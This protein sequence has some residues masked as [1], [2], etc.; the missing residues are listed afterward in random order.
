MRVAG[1]T[2]IA[3]GLVPTVIVA[4]STVLVAVSITETVPTETSLVT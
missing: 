1:V 3:M 2:A 4:A